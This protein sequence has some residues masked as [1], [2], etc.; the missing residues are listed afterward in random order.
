MKKVW[1]ALL[2]ILIV[3]LCLA[4][5]NELTY[6]TVQIIFSFLIL[7]GNEMSTAVSTIEFDISV[8]CTCCRNN[9][10][11]SVRVTLC[12]NLIICVCVTASTR[13]CCITACCTCRSCY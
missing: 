9:D 10:K 4:N 2:I 3:T 7:A 13:I 6:G 11:F 12:R 1:K 5:A 8:F